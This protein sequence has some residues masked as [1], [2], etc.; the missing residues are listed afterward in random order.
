L[1]LQTQFLDDTNEIIA[2]S[3]N[4]QTG[5]KINRIIEQGESWTGWNPKMHDFPGTVNEFGNYMDP[6]SRNSSIPDTFVGDSAQEG[7]PPVDK[8]T[9]NVVQNVAL[10][11]KN[12]N[13]TDA[14]FGTRTGS[15]YVTKAQGKTLAAEVACT[16]YQKC[17]DD[18]NNWLDSDDSYT[19]K[20]KYDAAWD[21]ADVNN[22][23]RI[24]AIGMSAFML[25]YLFKPLD[26]HLD[27][28]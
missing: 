11:G 14:G 13:K 26:D 8:F 15:L 9:Q 21:H 16:H 7:L 12:G 10:E 24:D 5:S 22:D 23:G 3:V 6:Y 4:V 20:S 19:G 25:R 27:L 17:G 18:A 1:F 28:Q 2:D